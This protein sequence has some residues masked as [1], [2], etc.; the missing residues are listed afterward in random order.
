MRKLT[1][2]YLRSPEEYRSSVGVKTFNVVPFLDGLTNSRV[3]A[4]FRSSLGAVII[5]SPVEQRE[6]TIMVRDANGTT[7]ETE[8]RVPG[9]VPA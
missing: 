5:G 9:T 3:T 7:T 4:S 6:G 2:H 1:W 8:T